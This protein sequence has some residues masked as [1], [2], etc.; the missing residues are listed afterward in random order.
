M[1]DRKKELVK[2]IARAGGHLHEVRGAREKLVQRAREQLDTMAPAIA[3]LEA[4]VE[5]GQADI[6]GQRRLRT[7][8]SERS[9]LAKVVE[10]H[11]ERTRRAGDRT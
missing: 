5:A 2:H 8:L 9:R 11:D 1:S 7:L 3:T 6:L 10:D 4:A